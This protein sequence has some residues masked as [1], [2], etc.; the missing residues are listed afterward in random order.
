MLFRSIATNELLGRLVP[1]MRIPSVGTLVALLLTFL[2]AYT[3]T[4]NYIWVLFG[5][6]NQLMASLALMIASIWL[7]S[8]R[9]NATFAIIPMVFMYLT[10]MAAIVVLSRQ[11]LQKAIAG[12]SNFNGQV[13]GNWVAAI[14]GIALFV[15]AL[16]LAWDGLKAFAR[17]RRERKETEPARAAG[18]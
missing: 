8:E 5:S 6:A 4:F 10:T 1:I 3:G 13:L 12:L 11:L 2:L 15:A 7:V 9:K 16:I 18:E 17:F 14:I